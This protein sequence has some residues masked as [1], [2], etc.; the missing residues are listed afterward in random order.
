MG[1]LESPPVFFKPLG[2]E[3]LRGISDRLGESLAGE[4]LASRPVTEEDV[5]LASNEMVDLISEKLDLAVDDL[6]AELAVIADP[7]LEGDPSRPP[8][9]GDDFLGGATGVEVTLGGE[10]LLLPKPVLDKDGGETDL[11][12]GDD[13]LSAEKDVDSALLVVA[14]NA[15]EEEEDA[16]FAELVLPNRTFGVSR[17]GF[18]SGISVLA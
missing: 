18:F 11:L 12:R 4:S 9:E 14:S 16:K 13:D 2:S 10:G 3:V 7:V 6:A 17:L 1:D 15:E 5:F 8:P